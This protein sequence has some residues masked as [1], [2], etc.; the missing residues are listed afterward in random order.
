MLAGLIVRLRALFLRRQSDAYLDA[1]MLYHLERETERNIARGMKPDDAATAARRAFGNVTVTTEQARDA[2]RWTWLEEL[3]QDVHYAAR[4]FRRAPALVATVALTIGLGLGLLVTTFTL[5]NA[6]VLR[7]LAVRDPRGLYDVTWR[8]RDGG[9]HSLTEDQYRRLARSDAGFVQTSGYRNLFTRLNGRSMVGQ[10]VSGSYFDMVGVPPAVGRLFTPAEDASPGTG[11]VVVLSNDTWRVLFGGDSAVVGRR[12]LVNGIPLTVIG[13]TPKGFGGLSEWPF[14]FWIPMSMG[15]ALSGWTRINTIAKTA[16]NTRMVGRLAPGVTPDEA[17]ARVAAWLT[18]DLPDAAPSSRV[19]RVLMESRATSMPLSPEM[20]AAFSPIA[21]AFLLVMLIACANVANMMLARGLARQ[22]EVGIRLALGAGRGRLIRQML[23]ESI[24]LALPAGLV[25]FAISRI[26]LDLGTRAMFATVPTEYA[27]YLRLV[28]LAPDLRVFFFVLGAAIAAAVA[29]G[30]LPALQATRPDIVRASRGDF[31]TQYR[32]SRLRNALVVG[33]VSVSVLLM[34]CAG[35]LLRTANDAK[36]LDPGFTARDVVLME[37]LERS[38]SRV[39]DAMAVLPG[40]RDVA[41]AAHYPLDGDF[42]RLEVDIAADSNVLARYNVV[43]PSYFAVMGLP[44]TRGRNFTDNEARGGGGA[45]VAL[46]SEGAASRFWPG[47]DPIGQSITLAD[48][49]S[50]QDHAPAFRS[51]RVVGVVHNAAPGWIGVS[52]S[53]PVIY[54]PQALAATTSVIIARVAGDA[55]VMRDRIDRAATAADSG[56]VQEIHTLKSSFELQAYPFRSAYWLAVIVG[57][58]ALGLTLTGVYGVIGYVVAQRRREFGIRLALGAQ[59][60]GL[61]AVVLRQAVRLTAIGFAVGAT[62]ALGVSRGF[63]ALLQ[64]VNTYDARGYAIAAVV[65]L[66]ACLVAAY[67][68][69]R[70]AG[71][72]NAVEALRADS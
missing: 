31:D 59:P 66:G 32:P 63:A 25:A 21:I 67:L 64:G 19:G 40:V 68:P 1:E 5:F 37:V 60:V 39:L 41:S 2:W 45:A 18:A 23:T 61:V 69:S 53:A 22:L 15:P 17:A 6:Y 71:K 72:V 48:K 51:A 30:T 28:D 70:R 12:I 36:A 14:Q 4:S 29:F 13:V 38:R 47:R 20:V 11:P 27:P 49:T 7:P 8:S 46:V 62:L 26:A 9:W 58:L 55:V 56:S 57:I 65:V 16:E 35:I 52:P 43:S 42:P 10:L 3:R 54:Y 44:I 33:Q 34:T 24:V 50:G